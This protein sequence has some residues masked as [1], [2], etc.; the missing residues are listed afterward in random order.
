MTQVRFLPQMLEKLTS[1]FKEFGPFGGLIYLID[2]MLS[3][4]SPKLRLYY[5]EL[6]IQPIP[7]APLLP[8]RIT[9]SLEFRQIS[10]QDPDMAHIHIPA[11]II[12]YRFAQGAICLGA[13]KQQEMI[14]YIWFSFDT[15]EEDEV[16]CTFVL[17]PSKESVFDFDLYLYPKYRL[18]FG[19]VSLWDGASGLL[20]DRGIRYTY[21]RLSRFNTESRRAHEHLGWKCVGRCVFLK[22]WNAELMFATLFPYVHFGVSNDSRVRLTMTPDALVANGSTD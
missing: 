17:Q 21:S 14:G 15:Y 3:S 16:R 18:G 1:P 11:E 4:I 10:Q 2:Q 13:Y 19:F 22:T 6:M 8:E 20:R 12:E 7:S 9:K 5:Y